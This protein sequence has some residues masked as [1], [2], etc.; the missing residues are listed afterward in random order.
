MKWED[1]GETERNAV[2]SVLVEQLSAAR[3]LIDKGPPDVATLSVLTERNAYHVL[4]AWDY[5]WDI[6][7]GVL[8]AIDKLDGTTTMKEKYDP[9][10]TGKRAILVRVEHVPAR[11]GK[12]APWR[13]LPE[14]PNNKLAQF[15]P[16]L[17]L[18]GLHG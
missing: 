7:A 16:V 17:P 15:F 14:N 3:T 6:H 11:D 1:I 10:D 8:A 2:R 4:S 12:D 13:S 9:L 18:F 5:L